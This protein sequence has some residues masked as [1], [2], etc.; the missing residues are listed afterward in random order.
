MNNLHCVD[1]LTLEQRNPDHQYSTLLQKILT[2]G[3]DKKPIHST[4]KENA[5]SG[6]SFARE[7][8]GK[9]CI[10]EFDMRNGF[11]VLTCRN[12]RKAFK[13]ALGELIGFLNGAETIDDLEAYGC[14]RRYWESWVTADKCRIFGL[15]PGHLGEGSYGPAFRNESGFDQLYALNRAIRDYPMSR[16]LVFSSWVPRLALG[17]QSQGFPRKVIVAPCHGD[18]VHVHIF[19][20]LRELE[21]VHVQRSADMCVGFQMNLIQWCAFG[22]MLAYLHGYKYTKYIHFVSSAQIYDT[23][24]DSARELIRRVP[25]PFPKVTIRLNNVVD[26]PWEFRP[27]DFVLEEY[28]ADPWF[29]IPTPI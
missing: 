15:Q 18:F 4:L 29:T 22:M 23:Q 7:L 13:G 5:G 14:P 12:L 25:H 26:C 16:T 9:S 2:E 20:E 3:K 11:P 19:P 21:L 10:L 24:F 8:T 6:H 28:E 1:Y 27:D 17:D